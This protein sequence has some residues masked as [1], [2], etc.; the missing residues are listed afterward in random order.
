M[1]TAA[2]AEVEMSRDHRVFN[3]IKYSMPFPVKKI[4][5]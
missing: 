2:E 3:K 1:G 4:S 5:L